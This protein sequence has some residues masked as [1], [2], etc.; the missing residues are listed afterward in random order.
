[1]ELLLEGI[2]GILTNY[3]CLLMSGINADG[4]KSCK[5]VLITEDGSKD[6]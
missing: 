3:M 6:C 4:E 5:K 1:M 2:K